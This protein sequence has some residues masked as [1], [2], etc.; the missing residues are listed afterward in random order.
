M[1]NNFHPSV[2]GFLDAANYTTK[3]KSDWSCASFYYHLENKFE[4]LEAEMLNFYLTYPPADRQ[5][6]IEA[7]VKHIDYYTR[8]Y[9]IAGDGDM[10]ESYLK[11]HILSIEDFFDKQ[12]R[13]SFLPCDS[14]PGCLK[15]SYSEL[16]EYSLSEHLH[17]E[18]LDMH[19]TFFFHIS[20]YYI[21][22]LINFIKTLPVSG[23]NSASKVVPIPEVKKEKVIP[24]A[25]TYN[26]FKNNLPA[27]NDVLVSLKKNKFISSDTS[28]TEFRK[29]FNNTKPD[30]TIQWIGNISELKYFVKLLHND[31]KLIINLK[32]D[33]W[34]VTSQ[35]FID[36]N[37][38][39]FDWTKFRAQKPP[40]RANLLELAVR[41]L[42]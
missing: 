19:F 41:H 38:K 21:E 39:P 36:K 25:F 15:Y 40:T 31:F 34:K 7:Y 30:N 28:I 5:I 1:S 4:K 17:R 42:E 12:V 10:A 8:N 13:R 26:R 14:F 9:Y 2:E 18:I 35:L 6:F 37:K 11:E 23:S 33:I 20:D 24:V 32:K 16:I 22:K 27:L 29:I 3:Y